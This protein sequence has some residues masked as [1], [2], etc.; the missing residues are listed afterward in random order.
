MFQKAYINYTIHLESLTL[1]DPVILEE[2]KIKRDLE[3]NRGY[4][5]LEKIYRGRL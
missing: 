4:V 3:S 1:P 2:P 5:V